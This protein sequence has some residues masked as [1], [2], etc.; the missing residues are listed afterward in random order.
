MKGES[1][2][3]SGKIFLCAIILFAGVLPSHAA[4]LETE[5]EKSAIEV[6]DSTMLRV[7]ISG[8]P[9]DVRPVKYPSV[10][11][12]KI[13]YAGMQRSF[14]FV[15][16]KTWSGA[17]LL[18]TVTG[19]RRGQY[20][21]PPL[22]FQRGKE[23][24]RSREVGLAVAAGSTGEIADLTD[25]KSA[26]AL[27]SITAHVGQPVIMR[28]YLM[29]GG[30]TVE[31]LG[32]KEPPGTKGFVVKM[33]DDPDHGSITRQGDHE[34][35]HVV[36]FALI[37]A[38]PGVYRVGGG[39][40]TALIQRTRRV[41]QDDFF[42]GFN[43]PMMSRIEQDIPC[44]TRPITVLS[45][46]A[47]GRPDN[48]Q[49][50]IGSFRI[51]A[52]YSEGAIKTYEEKKIKVTVEG[53]G[54]L[55]TMTKPLLERDVPGLKVISEEGENSVSLSGGTLRGSKTFTYTLIP[56]QAGQVSPGGFR[57][58]FFN[59]DSGRYETVE[60]KNISF[61]AK[62]GESRR[63]LAL[64]NEKQEQIDL[65]PLYVVLIILSV[66]G[67]IVFVVLWERKRYRMVAGGS[68]SGEPPGAMR[69][70]PDRRDYLAEAARCVASGDGDGFLSVA[71]KSLEQVRNGFGGTIPADMEI[72]IARIREEIYGYKFGRGK[73]AAGDMK[74]LYEEIAGLR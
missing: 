31:K 13:E 8:D 70:V 23:T 73:I 27:S 7:K 72:A 74:R 21:I 64:D 14:Q 40:L 11:G 5:I 48:F 71:E 36:S 17:E 51:S 62:G 22:A 66:A 54:N 6:G 41:E 47:H 57:F 49:G 52:N 9:E 46:P 32:F 34:K 30:L 19:L 10:P 50:D 16:G 28:Y 4:D 61:V 58:S 25:F 56:E 59:P 1:L 2:K 33:M 67:T 29:S 18:F 24:M 20:R 37:A 53:T 68:G 65:N 69:D 39:T 63:G 43:I 42:G 55:I 35:T 26:V 3:N 15:N 44:D 60:T 45:L 38:A 12:L